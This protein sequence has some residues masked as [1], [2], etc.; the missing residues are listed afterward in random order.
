[1]NL[2]HYSGTGTKIIHT[3]TILMLLRRKVQRCTF[4]ITVY[5]QT[6]L[7]K[8][9]AKA[10]CFVFQVLKLHFRNALSSESAIFAT[11]EVLT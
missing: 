11:F 1:M 9:R 3:K 10:C 6:T 8:M 7:C 4:T 5:G 2:F